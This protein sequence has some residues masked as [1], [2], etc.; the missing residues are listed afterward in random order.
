MGVAY[1]VLGSTA[2]AA[3]AVQDTYLAWQRVD[4]SG[5]RSAR[6]WLITVCTRR[7][8][9]LSTA[10]SRAKTSYVGT[11]LPEFVHTRVID[12]DPAEQVALASSV[13]TAFLLLLERLTPKERAAFVLHDVF[14]CNYAEIASTLELGEPACRQLV[15]RAR[16]HVGRSGVR[17]RTTPERQ[18]ELADAFRSAIADDAAVDALAELLADDVQLVSD[19]GGRVRAIRKTLSGRDAVVSFLRRVIGP[20]WRG[21]LLLDAEINA[22]RGVEVVE[23]GRITG[24]VSFDYDDEGRVSCIF[25]MRNPDKLDRLEHGQPFLT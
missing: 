25:V 10:A 24:A 8:I 18:Q 3:D 23:D 2:E 9:D 19:S 6:A 20:H 11:W 4:K 1:R 12:D 15:A 22:G 5:V 17:H 21:T 13:T 16:K 14:D 7:A